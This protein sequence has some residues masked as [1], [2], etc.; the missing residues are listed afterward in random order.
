MKQLLNV[1][2]ME[3]LNLT[4]YLKSLPLFSGVD[5]NRLSEVVSA[6]AV[7][8]YEKGAEISAD[9]PSLF[10]VIHGGA[11][12]YRVEGGRSV[13][14]NTIKSGGVFG[15]AQLFSTDS[16]FSSV[17][18]SCRCT[19]LVIP[20]TVVTELLRHDSRFTVNY[21]AFLSDRIKFLNKKIAAFTAGDGEKTLADYLLS[22]PENDGAVRLP[23]NM[24]RL[25]QYLNIS[26]PTLYRAFSSLSERG[27]IE[28]NG[29]AVKIISVEKLK[30]I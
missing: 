22:L 25:S 1:V 11:C 3:N 6:S 16:V 26:R 14:L 29:A 17:R 5:E 30:Q 9:A 12:V 21:I 7:L 24:S 27:I 19:C 8:S 13:I 4:E 18:A 28:K 15:A 2:N 10:C 23:S 20:R